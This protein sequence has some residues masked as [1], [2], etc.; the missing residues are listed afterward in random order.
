MAARS[1]GLVS[2]LP[3][4]LPALLQQQLLLRRHR[5]GPAPRRGMSGDP[6]AASLQF[7]DERVQSL[8]RRMT[9]LDLK[10]VFR[11][12]RQALKPPK[13]K[14]MTD[15]QLQEVMRNAYSEAERAL[16]PSPM[17]PERTPINDVLSRD[18]ML[19]GLEETPIVFTDISYSVPHR[20][21]FIVVREPDGTLRKASWEE[22]DRMLQVYFPRPGR[23]IIPPAVFSGEN[24]M[25][26][27]SAQRHE[28]ILNWCILQFEPDSHD[29]IQ[30][31]E[32]VY[33]DLYKRVATHTLHSTRHYPGLVWFLLK[34]RRIDSLLIDLIQRDRLED[35]VDL[36]SIFHLLHPESPFSK[37]ATLS[38]PEGIDLIQMFARLDAE[39]GAR[40]QLALQTHQEVPQGTANKAT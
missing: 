1:V 36:V 25:A 21:R 12:R 18:T 17:L 19:D 40:I 20:E 22:R 29:Y 23:R 8:L 2:R 16:T 15:A 7:A 34:T 5:P 28:Y 26:L 9:G 24:L 6:G 32:C 37:E 13:Y 31:H 35:A 10:K 39:N 14:L 4:P 33:E 11:P 27:L 30:V 3:A 38:R